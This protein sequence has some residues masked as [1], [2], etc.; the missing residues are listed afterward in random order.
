MA[1]RERKYPTIEHIQEVTSFK[2]QI[3][4]I[5][6]LETLKWL[7][8]GAPHKFDHLK[9]NF[10]FGMD[11][12]VAPL[13]QTEHEIPGKDCGTVCCI[14]GA[15]YAFSHR[16]HGNKYEGDPDMDKYFG[17]PQN[18][19]GYTRYVMPDDLKSLFYANHAFDL[20]SITAK[21]AAKTLRRYLK[22]GVVDWSHL[23]D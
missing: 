5:G 10:R 18:S 23:E 4:A 2:R 22:T 7:D 15:V 3:D 20:E 6:A 12:F 19:L 8:D 16:I 13:D 14:A 11:I 9:G 1:K 21:Q 17:Q